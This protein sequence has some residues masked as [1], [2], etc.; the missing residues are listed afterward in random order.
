MEVTV[1]GINLLP[2]RGQ[3]SRFAQKYQTPLKGYSQDELTTFLMGR[4]TAWVW[5]WASGI[6]SGLGRN[7]PKESFRG[8]GGFRMKMKLIL[9]TRYKFCGSLVPLVPRFQ[10]IKTAGHPF[11]TPLLSSCCSFQQ[12]L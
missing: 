6:L 7:D 11:L 2:Q 10:G 8:V 1:N 12:G 5:D 3:Y 9:T 4:R